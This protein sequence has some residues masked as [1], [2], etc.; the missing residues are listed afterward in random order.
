V[1]FS[2][3]SFL[4]FTLKI[5]MLSLIIKN[6]ALRSQTSGQRIKNFNSNTINSFFSTRST[7]RKPRSE[8]I[9]E[10][11]LKNI[12]RLLNSKDITNSN[13]AGVK[14]I[15]IF[16]ILVSV[17]IEINSI[18][19]FIFPFIGCLLGVLYAVLN[20]YVLHKFY[21]SHKKNKKILIPKILP[22]FLITKLEDLEMFS[23]TESGVKVV[24]DIYYKTII[25]SIIFAIIY[26]VIIFYYM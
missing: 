17:L 18:Y 26:L 21:V 6:S 10:K 3:A 13:P 11:K 4:I 2:L 23:Q 25:F 15:V 22:N 7:I 9:R 12:N 14:Y 24:K 16:T 20:L 8:K 1:L 19:V 5:N